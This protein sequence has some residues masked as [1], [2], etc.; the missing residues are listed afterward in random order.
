MVK[1]DEKPKEK[2]EDINDDPKKTVSDLERSRTEKF[3]T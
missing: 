3:I 2:E 1:K